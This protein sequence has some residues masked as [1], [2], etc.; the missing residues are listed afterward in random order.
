MFGPFNVNNY[1]NNMNAE[2]IDILLF[3]ILYYFRYKLLLDII[4]LV[5]T[6]IQIIA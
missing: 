4:V 2:Y 3:M 6:I 5:N 1:F